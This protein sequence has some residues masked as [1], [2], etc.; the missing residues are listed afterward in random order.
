MKKFTN[1]EEYKKIYNDINS[2]KRVLSN[3]IVSS[4][5]FEKLLNENRIFY[6]LVNNGVLIYIDNEDYYFTLYCISEDGNINIKK[7]DK[8]VVIKSMYHVN[9]KEKQ[10]RANSILEKAGFVLKDTMEQIV[11][12]PDKILKKINKPY[13]LS[14][15]IMNNEGL[16]LEKFP[17]ARLNELKEM[18]KNIA[19]IPYYQF[20]YFTDEELKKEIL[21]G[22]II[23]VRNKKNDEICG[24]RHFFLE[25][26][27]MYGWVVIK[28]EYKKRYGM[29]L[30]F[31]KYSLEYALNNGN[32]VTGW[33]TNT[34]F[35]SI[36]YHTKLGYTWSGRCMDD[37]ILE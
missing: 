31:T 4:E 22:R 34:N 11:G 6:E 20:D 9:K 27:N 18:Q 16:V 12:D 23:C 10:G 7:K 1:F 5:R 19:Q 2:N 14:L 26:N 25:K 28:D 37:W 13:E 8:P 21:E 17:I 33:I 30:I 29:A 15:R 32:L 36:N 24:I 35:E 3:G